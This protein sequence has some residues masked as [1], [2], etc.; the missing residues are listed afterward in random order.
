M[1]A[2]V[3]APAKVNLF[4]KV[5][6]KRPDGYH[7]LFSLMQPVSLY[8]EIEISVSEGEGI[9]VATDSPEAPG[10]SE[11]LAYKAAG[12]FL[13][14]AG[15]LKRVSISIKKRIPVGAGLGGG[16][17]D[18]A[19]VIMALDG[20]FGTGFSLQELMKLGARLGSDVPFFFLKGPALAKGRGE[21]LERANLPP[22]YYVL[23]NP[24]FHVPTAWVYSSL[25]LTKKSENNILLYSCEVFA[26]RE[27]LKKALTNDLEA[28][29]IGRYPEISALKEMLAE[30]GASGAL[31]SGSGPTVFGVFHS[32]ED[33]M[34][35]YRTLEPRLALPARI[36]FAEGL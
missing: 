20:L 13:V 3:L 1:Y 22:L 28:V 16:S 29:T 8:D 10:G 14:A 11:N 15:V 21:V 24:G 7:E 9:D 34:R 4:L 32:R 6:G 2:R 17:S 25:R 12:L 36:F 5:L 27:G 26:D 31:M 30:A 23:I 18:A 33:A 35:A 19:S